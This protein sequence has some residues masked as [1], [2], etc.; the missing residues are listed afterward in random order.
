LLLFLFVISV[1]CT[2]KKTSIKW[3]KDFP[4]I[5]SQS[6]PRTCDLNGDG[7][8]DIVMGAGRNEYQF[9][10]Q[11]I[12]AIDGKTGDPLWEQE[13]TDQVYGSATFLDINDDSVKDVFIGG[14]S[15]HFR[16]LDG[17]TGKVL[18]EY[19][20]E[21]YQNDS[22]LQYAR[23]NFNNSVLVPDQN[24]DGLD[25]LLTSN[26]GNSKANPASETNRFPGIL[27][28][29]DSKTGGIIAADSMPDGKETY[30]SPVAF[31]QP[32]EKE[33][34]IVFGSGGETISGNLFLGKLSDLLNN[35]LVNSKIIATEQ[36]HGFIAPAS[37]VDLNKD[38]LFDVV[39]ISHKST[40]FAVN[41]KNGKPLW[42]RNI[43]DTES[44]N[45]MAVGNFTNDDIPD[46]F[47]FVSEGEWPNSTGCVQVMLDGKNGNI[48]YTEEMG[49]TGFSSPAVYDLNDDGIDEA[50]ISVND[51]DCAR[52]FTSETLFTIKHKL[53]AIDFNKNEVFPINQSEGFKNIFST[54]WIG[55]LDNDGFLDIINCQY[56]SRGGLLTFLGMNIQRIDTHIKID[57][58]VQW[59]GYMGSNG[60]GVFKNED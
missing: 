37:V 13:A 42:E 7:V 35:K 9:S 16:A 51:Y 45:S 50:I 15:P 2:N 21:Q 33:P 32:G 14:R 26:G 46:L 29:F 38:G 23:Y 39:S 28:L 60:D 18:W 59:G 36:G 6:S 3:S 11:G 12:I 57:E 30:M 47:T 10:K 4:M 41:G 27:I 53:V 56:F 52:G 44:S 24:G 22:I 5:G 34:T 58:P 1:S 49:C 55:D 43:P 40:I 8:L 20:Y 25:D 31:M 48:V 19:K 54:P 17:K